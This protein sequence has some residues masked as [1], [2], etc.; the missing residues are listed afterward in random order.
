[1]SDDVAEATKGLPGIKSDIKEIQAQCK[2]IE[3]YKPP[4]GGPKV[5]IKSNMLTNMDDGDDN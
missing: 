3:S 5:E 1:M 4:S 2:Q